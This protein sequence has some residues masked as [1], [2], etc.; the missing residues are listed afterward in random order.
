MFD[1]LSQWISYQ[2]QGVPWWNWTLQGI[3]LLTAYVG[4]ELS[5][6]ICWALC[7]GVGT[8]RKLC[9]LG[10]GAGLRNEACS[11]E[12]ELGIDTCTWVGLGFGRR[13]ARL[14][15]FLNGDCFYRK[16]PL[17]ALPQTPNGCATLGPQT[18]SVPS[19]R[20]AA[21]SRS[22]AQMALN[23]LP[24]IT[25]VFWFCIVP[26]PSC[27]CPFWPHAQTLPSSSRARV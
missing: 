14:R 9:N 3:G 24:T 19:C 5:E 13:D 22:P 8:N 26:S 23:P 12:V 1:N 21:L 6:S 15:P 27:P 17:K 18:K 16:K 25:G 4:A 7:A 11:L 2:F 20:K 10:F